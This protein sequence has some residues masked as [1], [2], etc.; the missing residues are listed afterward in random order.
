ML[1]AAGPAGAET[2][3]SVGDSYSSGEGAGDYVPSSGGC[4]RS[5]KA[6]PLLV[7][8]REEHHLACSGATTE[9]VLRS[10]KGPD[11]D[12]QIDRLTTIA[13]AQR[14]VTVLLTIGGNDANFGAKIKSCR[15][16]AA[17]CLKDAA[18]LDDELADVTPRLMDAYRRLS[19]VPG[20]QRV[21]VVGYPDIT[22]TVDEGTHKCGWMTPSKTRNITRFSELLDAALAGAAAHAGVPYLSIRGALDEHEMCSRDPWIVPLTRAGRNPRDQQQGHP[23]KDGQQQIAAAVR[24][25]L[26]RDPA[27]AA[28]LLFDDGDDGASQ[29]RL[30]VQ[31]VDGRLARHRVIAVR[32]NGV[33]AGNVSSIVPLG[34]YLYVVF[35]SGDKPTTRIVRMTVDGRRMHELERDA[36]IDEASLAIAG[37]RIYWL[38][39][40]KAR[41]TGMET[42]TIARMNLDGSGRKTSW[43]K[44][45]GQEYV[46]DG[47]TGLTVAGSWLV[48]GRSYN[49][50][51]GRVGLDGRG[52]EPDWV[53][54]PQPPGFSSSVSSLAS[55]GTWIY[56]DNFNNDGKNRDSYVGRVRVTG[57]D[58]DLKWMHVGHYGPYGIATDGAFTYTGHEPVNPADPNSSG[59]VFITRRAVNGADSDRT[60]VPGGRII[61]LR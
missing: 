10:G 21:V 57:Q 33:D 40:G 4:H 23:T 32:S 30:W 58:V 46:D 2:F 50:G 55:D 42:R 51:L 19:Q 11:R 38:R 17:G 18:K 7:G 1:V 12:P 3:V 54:F 26:A 52:L 28:R 25:E 24:S 37:E 15:A 48:F 8:V 5:Q 44:L 39:D 59:P 56:F 43:V 31:S 16:N 14:D 49:D 27:P 29:S 6:W 53:R 13:A 9:H 61:A 20:V 47:A 60:T 45:P 36:R 35:S 41:E 22:P 34:N